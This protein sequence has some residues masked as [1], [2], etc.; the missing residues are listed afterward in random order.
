L[1]R[2]LPPFG[3]GS[4]GLG[5]RAL[6]RSGDG[7]VFADEIVATLKA[8]E[9]ASLAACVK[10]SPG[11]TL[12]EML[13]RLESCRQSGAL[14]AM[15][16]SA[17]LE[18]PPALPLKPVWPRKYGGAGQALRYACRMAS[19]SSQKGLSS[20]LFYSEPCPCEFRYN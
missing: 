6:I 8:C 7:P 13:Q 18:R 2:G 14:K 12:D 20:F 4:A 17:A 11:H 9:A 3:S 16:A 15:L 5:V 10:K 19:V 1:R